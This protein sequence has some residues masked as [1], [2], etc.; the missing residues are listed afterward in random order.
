MADA[1]EEVK[2]DQQRLAK[3]LKSSREGGVSMSE[4]KQAVADLATDITTM[5][6]QV[7]RGICYINTWP[8]LIPR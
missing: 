6:E 7:I 2:A 1:V 3:G 5:M 8:V 4:M